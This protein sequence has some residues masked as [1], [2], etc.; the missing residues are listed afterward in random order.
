M[1]TRGGMTVHPLPL[2]EQLTGL[3]Y[4]VSKEDLLRRAQEIGADTPVLHLLRTLP[5][6]RFHSPTELAE[7]L[8]EL[9]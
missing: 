2:L 9:D 1:G 4:P 8:A 3:D 6:D 7:V 5:V